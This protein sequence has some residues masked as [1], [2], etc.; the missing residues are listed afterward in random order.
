MPYSGEELEEIERDPARLRAYFWH[1][2][3]HNRRL[4]R[5]ERAASRAVGC[6]H[7]VTNYLPAFEEGADKIRLANLS[8]RLADLILEHIDGLVDSC[9]KRDD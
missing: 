2:A 7:P 8:D 3:M 9:L 5:R 1:I 4:A 6:S